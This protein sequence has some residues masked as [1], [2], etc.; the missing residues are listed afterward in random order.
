MSTRPI[1][2]FDRIHHLFDYDPLKGKLIRKV[3]TSHNTAPAG[4]VVKGT[5]EVQGYR[6]I[7]IDGRVYKYHRVVWFH[8]TGEWPVEIDHINRVKD[9]NRIENLRAVSRSE[10]QQNKTETSYNTS[11]C[12]GV[13]KVRN[14]WV[15]VIFSNGNRFHLGTF[16]TFEDAVAAYRGAQL[17][18]HPCRP[19]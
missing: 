5:L 3:T 7:K 14:G 1:V 8:Q 6:R 15:S 17:L 12:K 9:D 2:S 11:G 16:A 4:S 10:N 13:R 18:L 19:T